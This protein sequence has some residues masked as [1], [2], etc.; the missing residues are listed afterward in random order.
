MKIIIRIYICFLGIILLSGC[1]DLFEYHPYDVHVKGETGIN[2]K[3]SRK[4]KDA[5]LGKDTIRFVFTGDTQGWYDDTKDFVKAINNRNDID[6]IIHGGDLSDYGLTN[7]FIWM[8]DILGKLKVPYVALIGNHDCIG[9][10]KDTYLKIYG[11]RNFTF[12]AGNLKFIC[13]DTNA[14]EY[15]YSNP[16]PDFN[17]I[18]EQL[19]NEQELD[20]KTYFV[21]H[22]RPYSEQFNNNVARVFQLYINTFPNIQFCMNAHEHQVQIA[23]LYGDGILYYQCANIEKRNY[24]LFTI[25][26]DGYNYELVEF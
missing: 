23:D 10:G 15:D 4:I 8:R 2:E 9:S 14:L 13:L 17:F 20:M 16:V 11:E 25:K 24:F 19:G 22:A 6:F 7:E 18:E 12:T 21:M 3:N 26:P 1:K 5:C